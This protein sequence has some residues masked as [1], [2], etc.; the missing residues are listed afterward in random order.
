MGLGGKFSN[1]FYNR[2]FCGLKLP[3]GPRE[4]VLWVPL[5]IF[6]DLSHTLEFVHLLTVGNNFTN[7]RF[8]FPEIVFNEMLFDKIQ[9]NREI[10]LALHYPTDVVLCN[11]ARV[12]IPVLLFP[13]Y[14]K[15][16]ILSLQQARMG[17]PPPY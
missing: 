10:F 3:D 2:Q 7:L 4:L 13:F 8:D 17:P 15:N 9:K 16:G 1:F 14:N 12:Q 5:Y 6:L 11:C